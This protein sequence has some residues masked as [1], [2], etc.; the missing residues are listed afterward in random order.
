M[1]SLGWASVSHVMPWLGVDWILPTSSIHRQG[2]ACI[3]SSNNQNK[4][5]KG[6]QLIGA[7]L[8]YCAWSLSKG[9]LASHFL[10][11]HGLLRCCDIWF[12]LVR[13]CGI[14]ISV[15]QWECWIAIFGSWLYFI[16]TCLQAIKNLSIKWDWTRL[17]TYLLPFGNP[18]AGFISSKVIA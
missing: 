3:E 2:T 13:S 15:Y 17:P 18:K 10:A 11:F 7:K 12:Y 16:G 4:Y 14:T 8:V 5:W 9:I 1:L 6:C